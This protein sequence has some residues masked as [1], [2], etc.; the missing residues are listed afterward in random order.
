MDSWVAVMLDLMITKW[1]T[2]QICSRKIFEPVFCCDVLGL[3][4]RDFDTFSHYLVCSGNCVF[5][6]L[7]VTNDGL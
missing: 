2:F 4:H 5:T 3:T 7:N 1:E 6:D